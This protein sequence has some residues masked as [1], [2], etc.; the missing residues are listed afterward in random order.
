MLFNE[1]NDSPLSEMLT[2]AY[3]KA[4]PYAYDLLLYKIY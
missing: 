2:S 3:E 1:R 4:A